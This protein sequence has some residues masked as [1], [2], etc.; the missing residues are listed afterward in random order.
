M[1]QED[2]LGGKVARAAAAFCRSP[3]AREAST[4]QV[5]RS[6]TGLCGLKSSTMAFANVFFFFTVTLGKNTCQMER[7]KVHLH[8]PRLETKA[9][10]ILFALT[11]SNALEYFLFYCISL[12]K[13][14]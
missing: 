4:T 6:L 13:F 9:H 10:A 14:F 12:K 2:A 1:D 7:T 5:T 8:A 11:S 3:R